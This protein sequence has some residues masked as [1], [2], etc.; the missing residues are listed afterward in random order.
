M[1]LALRRNL[2]YNEQHHDGSPR[3]YR[4]DNPKR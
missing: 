3:L 4:T 2:F 1:P